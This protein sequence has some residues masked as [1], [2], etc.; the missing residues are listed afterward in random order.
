MGEETIPPH[1]R[2]FITE[3]VD[4]VMQLEALLLVASQP[5]R[6]WAAADLAQELRID[7][8]WVGTQLAGMAAQGLLDPAG[9]G[10]PT[11][12]RYHPRTA[13]LG[14]AVADLGQA[15]ADR[16]VTVISL[17]FSKPVDKLRSFADAF[18][19]RKDPPNG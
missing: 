16:R 5:Q 15:Y 13:D 17:I 10:S 1:V 14:Q 9:G 3:Y 4:S 19:I 6:E 18:K 12:F 7:P 8:A 11:R 2:A